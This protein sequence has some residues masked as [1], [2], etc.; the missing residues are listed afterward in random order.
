MTWLSLR[1]QLCR[2]HKN[3]RS[4]KGRTAPLHFKHLARTKSSFCLGQFSPSKEQISHC[5][6]ESQLSIFVGYNVV[7]GSSE[8]VE[9]LVHAKK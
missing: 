2:V 3:D 9:I 4:C 5:L 8:M 7:S 6:E 1:S